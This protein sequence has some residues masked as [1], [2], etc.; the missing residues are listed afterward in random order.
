MFK[1][2]EHALEQVTGLCPK[3]Q[4][5][6]NI[7]HG[8]SGAFIGCSQYPQC[9]FSK[10]LHEYE[11]ADVKVIEGSHCPECNANLVIKKG[12]FGLFIGCGNF[13]SCTYIESSKQSD[14]EKVKCPSCR[15]GY[16]AKKA[17]KFG[18]QFYPCNNYPKCKY[19]VN[20]MPV[21]TTCPACNWPIML[22]KKSAQG[23]LLQCPQR[24]CGHKQAQQ[25]VDNSL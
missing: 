9:D 16:L 1:A 15:D 20:F 25:T 17:N 11:T 22:E 4:S 8:K 10:P 21:A 3:C 19:V 13:P 5:S 7:K 6:L 23:M 14:V 12:R 18:K 24:L 2:S